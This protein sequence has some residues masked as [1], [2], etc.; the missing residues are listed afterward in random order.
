MLMN[1]A[2]GFTRLRAGVAGLEQAA[3]RQRRTALDAPL[4]QR[5]AR[6][7]GVDRNAAHSACTHPSA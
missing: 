2:E 5:T 4:L 1:Q 7:A 6:I 3:R